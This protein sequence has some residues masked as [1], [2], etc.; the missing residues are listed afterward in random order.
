M[1]FNLVK[2]TSVVTAT[3]V[4]MTGTTSAAV[5]G[6]KERGL[7]CDSG[8]GEPCGSISFSAPLLGLNPQPAIMPCTEGLSCVTKCDLELTPLSIIR[9]SAIVGVSVVYAWKRINTHNEFEQTC[10]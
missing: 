1:Q 6:V 5:L 9:V 8:V 3:L 7:T 2:L 4:M 10:A